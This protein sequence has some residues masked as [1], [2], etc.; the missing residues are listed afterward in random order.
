MRL[1]QEA[2]EYLV[3]DLRNKLAEARGDVVGS[4]GATASQ[5][6][7]PGKGSASGAMASASAAKRTSKSVDFAREVELAEEVAVLRRRGK[8]RE[9][10]L[11]IARDL[12]EEKDA[13]LKLLENRFALAGPGQEAAERER[14]KFV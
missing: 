6:Q 7:T 2:L 12:W 13:A 4:S 1:K 9:Q 5:A 3:E 11:S 8:E 14:E 10:E